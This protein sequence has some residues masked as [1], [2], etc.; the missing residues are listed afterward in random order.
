MKETRQ[1]CRIRGTG[2]AGDAVLI[3]YCQA[4]GRAVPMCAP[5]NRAWRERAR[6]DSGLAARCPLCAPSWLATQS[7]P[8]VAAVPAPAGTMLSG[9]VA[10]LLDAAMKAE[11][12][13]VDVRQR[14]LLRLGSE[15]SL[16]E[17]SYAGRLPARD[18]PAHDRDSHPGNLGSAP[19]EE[20]PPH[21]A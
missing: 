10:D 7:S 16:Q 15:P 9:P 19:Q 12:L 11:G 21:W 6:G 5:C 8:A 17:G 18:G 20:W 13:L 4:E 1:Q 3:M 2:C 14:V